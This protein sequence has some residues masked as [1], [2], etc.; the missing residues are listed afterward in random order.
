M[1]FWRGWGILSP[2]IAIAGFFA[3]AAFVGGLGLPRGLANYPIPAG[4]LVA[5]VGNWFLGR[6][7]NQSRREAQAGAINRHSLFFVPMEWWSV[8][9][10]GLAALFFFSL[11]KA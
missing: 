9:M 5:A 4:L 1:I 8:V 6:W 2:F 7:L 3:G 10:L 11:G